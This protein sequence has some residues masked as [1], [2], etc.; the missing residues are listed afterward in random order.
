MSKFKFTGAVDGNVSLPHVAQYGVSLYFVPNLPCDMD[1]G[2]PWGYEHCVSHFARFNCLYS[3]RQCTP[4]FGLRASVKLHERANHFWLNPF[5]VKCHVSPYGA[6][7]FQSLGRSL[8]CTR[9][10]QLLLRPLV[11]NRLTVLRPRNTYPM[12]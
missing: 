3:H 11:T 1:L 4:V 7:P 2:H 6:E 12:P 5:M 9:P 8:L 10:E